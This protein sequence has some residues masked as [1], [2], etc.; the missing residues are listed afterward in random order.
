M[1]RQTQEGQRRPRG[2]SDPAPQGADQ[3]KAPDSQRM[4][5]FLRQLRCE[6]DV[7]QEALAERLGVSARTVSRWEN[8][9]T[10]PDLVM[11]VELA[12]SFGVSIPELVGGSRKEPTM[13]AATEETARTMA[14]YG[15]HELRA[16]RRK[17]VAAM[18]VAFGALVVISALAVFPPDSSWG[19]VYAI[20]GAVVVVAATWELLGGVGTTRRAQ[21]AATATLAVAFAAVFLLS[22]YVGVTQFNQPPRFCYQKEYTADSANRERMVWRTPLYSV[23]SDDPSDPS[24]P[25]R[26]QAH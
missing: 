18:L 15:E 5:E 24:A 3:T 25:L 8:G 9:T 17:T 10:M 6:Q 20:V 16:R 22:D 12:K 1:E 14:T 11:V 4:G 21:V 13:D 7:T 2:E 23:V 19:S 26:I